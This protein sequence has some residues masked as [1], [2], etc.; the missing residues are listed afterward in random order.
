LN[1]LPNGWRRVALADLGEWYGGGTP[2]KSQPEF[3]TGGSVHWLSPKDMG[4]EV[5]HSTRDLITEAAIV[6][7]AVRRIPAGSVALVVRS[8]ILERTL[9]IAV[10]PFAVTLNQDMKA[11]VPRPDI[12]ARWIAWGLRNQERELLRRCRKG[13]TT[14]ASIETSRLLEQELPV[15]P[16]REQRRIVQ[17][18]EEHLSRLDGGTRGLVSTARRLNVLTSSQIEGTRRLA[19]SG[20]A[21]LRLGELAVDSGYGT[22]T[23]CVAH[24]VGAAVVRIPNLRAGGIDLSDEKRVE[25]PAVDVSSYLLAA[26]DLLIVRTNGSRDLIGRTAVV[27]PEIDAAFASYL[28]RYRFDTS[29]VR[30]EWIQLMMQ[31]ASSRSVLESMAASSAGQYNLSMSKLDTVPV[32]VPELQDQDRFLME[33]G[34]VVEAAQRARLAISKTG[35][36]VIALRR[37]LLSAA[38]SGRL[39]NHVSRRAPVEEFAGV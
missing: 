7:S 8:G 5:L 26:G 6:G 19:E 37:A 21:V 35:E 3:W 12:D 30:P 32:P 31:S 1:D 27:P 23:K 33:C 24:G 10:V 22:S 38:F 11:V 18:L 4:A 34:L 16:L 36:R 2:S 28:I 17:S 15:P 29:R 20:D 25:D 39:S 9:P 14:V 13:G